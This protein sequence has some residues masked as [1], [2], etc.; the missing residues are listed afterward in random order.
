MMNS[1]GLALAEVVDNR[2]PQK[3][4]KVKITFPWLEGVNDSSGWVP[5]AAPFGA[6]KHQLPIIPEVGS[7]VVVGFLHNDV[8][9]PVVL[10]QVVTD[11]A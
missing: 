2:D 9:Q 10:G 4:A 1:L 3:L 5:L 7:T 6:K 8:L 11:I